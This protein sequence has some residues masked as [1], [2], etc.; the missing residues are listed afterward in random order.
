MI[1]FSYEENTVR[2]RVDGPG[3]QGFVCLRLNNGIV[4]MLKSIVLSICF[5]DQS[6]FQTTRNPRPHIYARSRAPRQARFKIGVQKA[7]IPP[8]LQKQ[9]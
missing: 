4:K 1:F 8:A 7:H 2:V 9:N 3:A 5:K 6:E